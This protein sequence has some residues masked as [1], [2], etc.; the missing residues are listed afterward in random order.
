MQDV[1]AT[2]ATEPTQGLDVGEIRRK[3]GSAFRARPVVYWADMLVSAAIGWAAFIASVTSEFGS[4]EAFGYL[5]VAIFAHLRAVLFIHEIAHFKGD[6]MRGFET[7]WNIAVGAPLQV[8]SLMYVGSHNEHHKRN[9]FGT[10]EDPEYAPIAGYS[11]LKLSFFVLSVAFVPL[12]LPLRWGVLS[13]LSFIF[14]PLRKLA[15]ER[16]ST[17]GINPNYRRPMPK[18]S[19][20]QR[21]KRQ[22]LTLCAVFWLAVAAYAAGFIG[23]QFWISWV[24]LASGILLINQ[25]RTLVAHRYENDGSECDSAD[26]LLDSVNLRGVPVLTALVAPVGLRYHALHHLLPAVP[27]HSLGG[28]HRKLRRELPQGAPYHQT[29]EAGVWVAVRNLWRKAQLRETAPSAR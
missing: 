28:L 5:G 19:Q 15:V 4:L 18:G 14:P 1:T 9:G 25:V 23:L 7:G 3:Y 22:E 24:G 21:W 29:E 17:L 10:F 11:R 27:Y 20:A 16:L 8:P 2:S 6:T 26:Q 13:P 12:V